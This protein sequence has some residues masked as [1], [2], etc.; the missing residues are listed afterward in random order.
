MYKSINF[1]PA[2]KNYVK[3]VIL[4]PFLNISHI[5]FST[6]INARLWKGCETEEKKEKQVIFPLPIRLLPKSKRLVGTCDM[7][8]GNVSKLIGV[9]ANTYLYFGIFFRNLYG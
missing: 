6:N 3:F 4:P 1:H 8:G 7:Y 5:V 9:G 2:F